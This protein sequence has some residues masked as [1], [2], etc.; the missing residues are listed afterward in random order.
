MMEMSENDQHTG[1]KQDTSENVEISNA[2]ITNL[3]I[4]GTRRCSKTLNREAMVEKLGNAKTARK[5][6][7]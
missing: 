4:K 5:S 6:L 2:P 3:K 7:K 1:S